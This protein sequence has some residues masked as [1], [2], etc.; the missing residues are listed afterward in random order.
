MAARK[1]LSELRSIGMLPEKRTVARMFLLNLAGHHLRF[2]QRFRNLNIPLLSLATS[3][4]MSF[5]GCGNY[6]ITK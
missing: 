5:T 2:I 3:V 1:Q 6:F 4:I